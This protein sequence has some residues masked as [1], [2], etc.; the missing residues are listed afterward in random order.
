M[1][2]ASETMLDRKNLYVASP[3]QTVVYGSLKNRQQTLKASGWY[4][5]TGNCA[6]DV[7]W[8]K[9]TTCNCTESVVLGCDSVHSSGSERASMLRGTVCG[10]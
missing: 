7:R 6:R 4:V 8:Q 3:I 1:M 5:T 10:D 2:D 9:T